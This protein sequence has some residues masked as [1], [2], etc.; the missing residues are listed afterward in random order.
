MNIPGLT[1]SIKAGP[2]SAGGGLYLHI[3]SDIPLRTLNTSIW[4]GGFGLHR[5]LVNRQVSKAYDCPEPA[6][7]M[8]Q[9]LH[10]CGLPSGEACGMLTAAR[11]EDGARAAFSHCWQENGQAMAFAVTAWVT[12]GLGNTARAGSI[13]PTESLYPGTVNMIV[14]V[15][16][17]LSDAAMAGAIITATEA[18]AA[19]FQE[20]D[21][22]VRDT[23]LLATG[24]T[25]DAVLI[26]ATG[27]GG[28]CFA[29]TGSS[30][31]PGYY[32]GRAV[33]EATLE[34][35]RR[36]LERHAGHFPGLS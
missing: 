13:Q 19:A 11:V 35:C 8:Q 24:T 4:G 10:A 17:Q 27:R 29:Y 15:D 25:T 9:F 14:A 30:T 23:G 22:R 5:H 32:I 6:Q 31:I 26:A 33:Y 18:K 20:L 34:A 36:N 12:A 1:A 3:E 7:D 16:G 28:R 21:I 2:A